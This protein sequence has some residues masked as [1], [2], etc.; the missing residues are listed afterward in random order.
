MSITKD[1]VLKTAKLA[2]LRI[3][4]DKISLYVQE[5]SNVLGV[6]DELKSADTQGVEPLV[7]VNEFDMELREDKV[8][9]GD[10]SKEVLKNAPKEK[11]GYFVVPKVIE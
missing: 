2:R 4:E 10:C 3:N 5:L 6:I 7:N 1:T 11:F 8:Q 9:Y